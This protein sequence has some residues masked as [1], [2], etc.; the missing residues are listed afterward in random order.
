MS[1]PVE[2]HR[3]DRHTFRR[4]LAREIRELLDRLPRDPELVTPEVFFALNGLANALDAGQPVSRETVAAALRALNKIML[5]VHAELGDAL[6]SLGNRV[7]QILAASSKGMPVRCADGGSNTRDGVRRLLEVHIG[8]ITNI[9]FRRSLAGQPTIAAF[10]A[11]RDDARVV[12]GTLVLHTSESDGRIVF[13]AE[14]NLDANSRSAGTQDTRLQAVARRGRDLIRRLHDEP[15]TAAP[16][17][18]ATIVAL[19]EEVETVDE[20]PRAFNPEAVADAGRELLRWTFEHPERA[21]PD[22]R[23]EL[24]TLIDRA[25]VSMRETSA[26]RVARRFRQNLIAAR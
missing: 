21:T 20:S 7:A 22:M 2:A 24:R 13:R 16:E 26:Q 8:R 5:G 10:D 11:V 6:T 25:E 17:L 14:I 15:N 18:V 4:G 9:V 3:D 1:T 23:A 12:T 19:V